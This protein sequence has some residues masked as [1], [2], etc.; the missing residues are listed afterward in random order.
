MTA[1]AYSGSSITTYVLNILPYQNPSI[2]ISTN[3]TNTVLSTNLTTAGA[4]YGQYEFSIFSQTNGVTFDEQKCTLIPALK[5]PAALRL[6]DVSQSDDYIQPSSGGSPFSFQPASLLCSRIRILRGGLG[7]QIRD[8]A[9]HSV[10]CPTLPNS[11]GH[12]GRRERKRYVSGYEYRIRSGFT[13]KNRCIRTSRPSPIRWGTISN[14]PSYGVFTSPGP[15]LMSIATDKAS[16]W[17]VVEQG[18]NSN[19]GGEYSVIRTSANDGLTWTDVSVSPFVVRSSNSY[20]HYNNGR[21]FLAQ[22]ERSLLRK[23]LIHYAV[24]EHWTYGWLVGNVPRV[25]Q[26]QDPRI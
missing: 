19:T 4:L 11:Q 21:Y 2:D 12:A 15:L 20:L 14:V 1:I 8:T 5:P 22:P 26:Q 9:I 7:S 23:R 25:Q 10:I 16:N 13:G 24:V 18:F 3:A 6:M 17:V